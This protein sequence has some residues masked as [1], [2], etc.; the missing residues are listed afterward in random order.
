MRRLGPPFASAFLRPL[1]RFMLAL[2]N[3]DVNPIRD[4][5]EDVNER[6]PPIAP[7]HVSNTH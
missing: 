6:M 2:D 1:S 3:C 4:A 7:F 5:F